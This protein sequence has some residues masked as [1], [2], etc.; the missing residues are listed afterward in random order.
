MDVKTAF[1]Y[2]LIRLTQFIHVRRP[3]G[4]T[5]ADRPAVIRLRK[6]IFGLPHAPA[7]FRAH[8]DATLRSYGFTPKISDPRLYGSL[9]VDDTEAYVVVHEYDFGIAA[10]MPALMTKTVATIA[11]V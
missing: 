6:C 3:V 8:S 10:S 9:P 1:F 7:T 2:D 11:S 5:D 4:L